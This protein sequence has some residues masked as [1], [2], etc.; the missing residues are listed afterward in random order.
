MRRKKTPVNP[1]MGGLVAPSVALHIFCAATCHP[2]IN[3]TACCPRQVPAHS[4]PA[5]SKAVSAVCGWGIYFRQKK[6][7]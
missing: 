3:L 1:S 7:V 4:S 6:D 5:N 2:L